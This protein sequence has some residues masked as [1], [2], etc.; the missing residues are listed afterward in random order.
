M[1]VRFELPSVT[2][3]IWHIWALRTSCSSPAPEVAS[4]L[5]SP[6]WSCQGLPSS[7]SCAF[8]EGHFPNLPPV[9]LLD[10]AQVAV[11]NSELS[12]LKGVSLMVIPC[13][14]CVPSS[15]SSHPFYGCIPIFPILYCGVLPFCSHAAMFSLLS[16]QRSYS[17]LVFVPIFFCPALPP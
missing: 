13:S 15:A 12:A 17:E 4:P 10:M 8:P 11:S 6:Y 16:G 14:Q 7:P 9:A 1:E 2:W 5:F 3:Y